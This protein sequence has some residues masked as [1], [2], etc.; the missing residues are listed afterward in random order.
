MTRFG[1][2]A[3]KKLTA[4][5]LLNVPVSF[6]KDARLED[7]FNAL[8]PK[9]Q[10]TALKSLRELYS[11][12]GQFEPIELAITLQGELTLVI[13]VAIPDVMERVAF[14]QQFVVE[15]SSKEYSTVSDKRT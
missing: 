11:E 9:Q 2:E 15:K 12:K 8:V 10:R 13:S 6:N 1:A 14:W 7:T 5:F 4:E 3:D